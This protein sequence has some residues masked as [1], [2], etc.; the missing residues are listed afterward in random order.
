M[1]KRYLTDE[2][3]EPKYL[4]FSVGHKKKI[5]YKCRKYN[6]V[7]DNRISDVIVILGWYFYNFRDYSIRVLSIEFV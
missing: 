3:A 5:D 1:Y 2:M 4:D 6:L 7:Y